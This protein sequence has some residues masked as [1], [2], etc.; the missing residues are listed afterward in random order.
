MPIDYYD[1]DKF[2]DRQWDSEFV[3][4]VLPGAVVSGRY[5]SRT[6]ETLLLDSVLV[7]TGSSQIQIDTIRVPIERILAWG[8]GEIR[9]AQ[10]KDAT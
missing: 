2:L 5:V 9:D 7:C 1:L 6:P 8:E 10:S 3:H 4:F